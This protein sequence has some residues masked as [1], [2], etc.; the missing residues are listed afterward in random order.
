[1]QEEFLRSQKF[2][3]NILSAVFGNLKYSFE[4]D[5]KS[6]VHRKKDSDTI[7]LQNRQNIFQVSI[8]I[9]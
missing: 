5:T 8:S 7:F 3:G 1:M 2:F 4:T 9:G 6:T